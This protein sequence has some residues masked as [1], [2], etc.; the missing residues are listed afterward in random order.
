MIAPPAMNFSD[1]S[2]EEL[3]V[4]MGCMIVFAFCFFLIAYFVDPP[5]K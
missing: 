3:L 4:G 1:W 5:Y 2:T